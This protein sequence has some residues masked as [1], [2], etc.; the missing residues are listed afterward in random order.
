M[1][2]LFLKLG[3]YLASSC[4]HDVVGPEEATLQGQ[5]HSHCSAELGLGVAGTL[6]GDE[7]NLPRIACVACVYRM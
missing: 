5:R 3:K 1:K 4:L 7:R 6:A 2:H